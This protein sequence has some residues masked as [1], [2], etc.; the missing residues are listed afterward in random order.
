VW[1][2]LFT[3]TA[4]LSFTWLSVT[5]L[6]FTQLPSFF[7]SEGISIEEEGITAL[8]EIGARTS[9]RYAVQLLTPSRILAETQGRDTICSDD[10][11]EIDLI[12]YDAKA[13][14]CVCVCVCVWGG[15]CFPLP[16]NGQSTDQSMVCF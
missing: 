11:E 5:R 7:L 10:I 15:H 14:V 4:R 6:S 3:H 9:L 16:L 2:Y 1:F 13:S 12:F 8:G